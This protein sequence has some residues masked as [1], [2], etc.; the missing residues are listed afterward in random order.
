M[1]SQAIQQPICPDNI[2][3]E[4][5]DDSDGEVLDASIQRAVTSVMNSGEI[6]VA[7]TANTHNNDQNQILIEGVKTTDNKRHAICIL[8]L[9]GIALSSA[10]AIAAVI[11]SRISPSGSHFV[12][13]T[14]VPVIPS[15]NIT[16]S[17]T[18][19][20]Y[21]N[22]NM[23]IVNE[24]TN[25]QGPSISMVPGG[26]LFIELINQ[27]DTNFTF[28]GI[29]KD[30]Q[31]PDSSDSLLVSKLVSPLWSSHVVRSSNCW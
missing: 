25:G 16:M 31:I 9:G 12:P 3:S 17:N 29:D 4:N 20:T 6:F 1:V 26:R 11:S 24:L 8:L 13:P 18:A 2:V 19:V 14:V 15:S 7:E 27:T 5:D 30:A 23:T 28:F 21:W 10:A 22:G